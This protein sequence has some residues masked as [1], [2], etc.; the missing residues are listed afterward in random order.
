MYYSFN[1]LAR[2]IADEWE[3]TSHGGYR[4]TSM[5]VGDTVIYDINDEEYDDNTGNGN[6]LQCNSKIAETG[7]T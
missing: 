4:D 6:V 3:N 2:T 7:Q 5:M 1:S